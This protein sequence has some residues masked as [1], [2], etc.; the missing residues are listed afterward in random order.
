MAALE[1]PKR[2]I[3]GFQLLIELDDDKMKRLIGAM[4]SPDVKPT[5]RTRN[6]AEQIAAKLTDIKPDDVRRIVTTIR[7]LYYL[8]NHREELADKLVPDIIEGIEDSQDLNKEN[9]QKDKFA[10]YLTQ[11]LNIDGTLTVIAKAWG[12]L[13]DHEHIFC[14]ARILTDIRPVFGSDVDVSPDSVV[15]VHMLKIGYHEGA[16]HKEFFV[17]LDK[18]DL[19]ELREILDR[20]AKKTRSI[21]RRLEQAGMTD[22]G[23]PEQE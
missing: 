5:L 20:E 7:S 14:N 12:V 2:Y 1:I 3:S 17:A 8:L 19:R 22:L 15:T 18:S 23:D 13:T 10:N 9:W 4:S 6:L 21:L 11:I 16:E